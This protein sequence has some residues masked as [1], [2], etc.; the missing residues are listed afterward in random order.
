VFP[1]TF[2]EGGSRSAVYPK[3]EPAPQKASPNARL[4]QELSDLT[5]A[6]FEHYRE[7]GFA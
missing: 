7:Q 4:F 3:I 5:R 1:F 6:A 2:F